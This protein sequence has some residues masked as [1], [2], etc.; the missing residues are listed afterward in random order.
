MLKLRLGTVKQ[1]K[2]SQK[3]LR[4]NL[5]GEGCQF[6]KT[7]HV[8]ETKKKNTPTVSKNLAC[9]DYVYGE[10]LATRQRNIFIPVISII[11]VSLS[12]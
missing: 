11:K 10:I 5:E 6:S 7:I 4:S 8:K 1:E 2:T 9:E 3:T 12:S